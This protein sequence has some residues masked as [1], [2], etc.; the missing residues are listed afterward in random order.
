MAQKSV[1]PKLESES[2]LRS[3]QDYLYA[4]T[5][6]AIENNEL[7][8]FKN[9]L[10][11]AKSEVAIITAI[12]KIKSNHGSMTAGTD[13]VM[14][15]DILQKQY[16]E[17]INMVH[18]LLDNY[19]PN[20]LRRVWI[21][22][23]GKA[24][25][26]P[27]GIPAITDRIIQEILRMI[28]EPIME[29]QFFKHSYGFRPMRDTHMALGRT[30]N[31]CHKTGYHWI[32]EGDIKGCFDNINHT[33]L[34]KQLWHMGIHD[35][36][37]LMIIKKMLKT[38]VLDEIKTTELGTPQG[39]IISPLLANVYLHKLDQWI[40]REWEEKK[41]RH[42][43]TQQGIKN[44]MLKKKT[45]LKPVYLIRYADDWILVTN[46]KANAEKW[47]KRIEKYLDINLKLTLS[48]TKTLITNI[49]K[50]PI[51]FLGF[52]C[53]QIKGK[54][55]TGWIHR[56]RPDKERL[57][58]KVYE[59]KNKIHRL[60]KYNGKELIHQ[61]NIINSIIT[62]ISNYYKPATMVSAEL[63]KHANSLQYTSY[64]A[65]KNK[66][67][68]WTPANQVNNLINRHTNYTTQIPSIQHE[69]LTIGITSLGF[70]KWEKTYLK[71]P[72]ETP[73]T[74]KGRKIYKERTNKAKSL[75]RDDLTLSLTLSELIAK[76]L[77][78]PRYNFEYLMNRA[79]AFNR[80]KGKCRVCGK[81][82]AD[83]ELETHHTHPS[84]PLDQVNKVIHLASTHD[85]CHV[86]IHNGKD[87][88]NLVDK[89][90]WKK[91]LKFRETL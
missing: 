33:K 84:L 42:K 71:N 65:I 90:T 85:Y 80:D 7:P 67:A 34:I 69:S 75:A 66:G 30:T 15:A 55:R 47:K 24:E 44:K 3:I 25:K 12:H 78:H 41:T 45:N 21:P 13:G 63:N 26:R 49:R 74:P 50:K 54:S 2:D 9:L 5:K 70:V 82:I 14:I 16:P 59:L 88:S 39:G 22:K 10:E 58:A 6:Q 17:V 11:I 62:G 72:D 73:Y 51:H 23:L 36:R 56:T 46:T 37:I 8:K 52:R 64:K 48:P 61:I 81:P 86:L 60:L 1:Y 77:K 68:K 76:G 19:D 40:V 20:L 31:V 27:L 4:T 87:L 28:I 18:Q 89:K 43:Y 38:G 32:I 83:Y 53:K 57:K 29:A 79:Y 35:R 91:I